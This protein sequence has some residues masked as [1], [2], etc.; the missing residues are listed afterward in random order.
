MDNLFVDPGPAPDGEERFETLF[1]G[2]RGLFVE[3]IVSHG[4]KT[5]D[6]M[7]YDMDHDEWVLIL[8]G[9]AVLGFEDGASKRLGKGDCCFLPCGRRHRVEYT[10]SPCLWLAVHG[11]LVPHEK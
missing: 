7:W 10:S 11:E 4:Q 1:R 9:D 8:E 3:R 2:P 6:N 5:P